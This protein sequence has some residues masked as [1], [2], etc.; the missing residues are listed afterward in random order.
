MEPQE[1][2]RSSVEICR[3]ARFH[4]L[5][6]NQSK[7]LGAALNLQ[8]SFLTLCCLSRSVF[9]NRVVKSLKQI[10]DKCSVSAGVGRN[11]AGSRCDNDFEL[12]S[13]ANQSPKPTRSKLEAFCRHDV[14]D[15][16]SF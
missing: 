3:L 9:G 12:F 15:C 1:Q 7:P 6:Q 8:R 13:F 16:I 4:V 11:F 10:S 2:F 5:I 14:A